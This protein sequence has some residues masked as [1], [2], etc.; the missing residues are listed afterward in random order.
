MR[1]FLNS[2][3]CNSPNSQKKLKKETKLVSVKHKQE[4]KYNSIEVKNEII[5]GESIVY[6]LR[7]ENLISF[8]HFTIDVA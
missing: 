1:I 8:C 6:K 4:R 5:Y 2:L 7:A 3:L